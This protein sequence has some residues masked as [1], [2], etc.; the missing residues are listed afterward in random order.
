[1][2]RKRVLPAD[3]DGP[4]FRMVRLW[5]V[6]GAMKGEMV[7]AADTPSEATNRTHAGPGHLIAVDRRGDI[8]ADNHQPTQEYV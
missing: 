3:A 6:N 4:R 7:G 5:K 2:S 8:Y 1:M